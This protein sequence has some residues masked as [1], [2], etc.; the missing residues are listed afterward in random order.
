MS[1]DPYVKELDAAVTE[2]KHNREWRREYMTLEMKYKEKYNDECKEFVYATMGYDGVYWLADA[3][4]RAG[5]VDRDAIR[6]A[7]EDT[8]DLK[9]RHCVLTIDP[10][11]H[12]PYKKTGVILKIDDDLKAKFYKKLEAN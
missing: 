3:I 5:K 4:K 12:D 6:D 1:D 9:L 7:L 10:K 2:A 11:T 8:K